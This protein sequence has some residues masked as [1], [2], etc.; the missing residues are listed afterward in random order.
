M[1]ANMSTFNKKA[2]N[3]PFISNIHLNNRKGINIGIFTTVGQLQIPL[4]V[5]F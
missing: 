1:L 2:K 4:S 5:A 3:M